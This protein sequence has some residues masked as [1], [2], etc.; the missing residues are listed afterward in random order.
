MA[1]QLWLMHEGQILTGI[2]EDLVL[3]GTLAQVFEQPGISFDSHTGTFKV[4]HGEGRAVGLD[5]EMPALFWTRR[6]LE[7]VGYSVVDSATNTLSV[8]AAA[9]PLQWTVRHQHQVIH[10]GT[11]AELLAELANR[12]R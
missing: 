11:L 10:C 9:Q 1:D 12:S 4:A 5:G 6:A 3:R 8:Y 2:P 7:R